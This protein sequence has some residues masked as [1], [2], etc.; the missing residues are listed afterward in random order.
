MSFNIVTTASSCFARYADK[1][2]RADDRRVPLGTAVEPTLR[3][4]LELGHEEEQLNFPAPPSANTLQPAH[5]MVSS[6][7]GPTK[8]CSWAARPLLGDI[9]VTKPSPLSAPETRV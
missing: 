7:L 3:H 4:L 6:T 8:N 2:L 9:G 1:Q 5:P